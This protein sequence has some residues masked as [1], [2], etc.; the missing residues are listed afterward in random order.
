MTRGTNYNIECP[1]CTKINHY[2]LKSKILN[3]DVILIFKDICSNCKGL[4]AYEA[5]FEIVLT[6]LTDREAYAKYRGNNE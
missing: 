5:R 2:P 3:H 1:Y 4:I 6:A